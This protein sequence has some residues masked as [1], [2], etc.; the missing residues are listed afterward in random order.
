MNDITLFLTSLFSYVYSY[1]TSEINPRP[2]VSQITNN[3]DMKVVN[4]YFVIIL[5]I[6]IRSTNNICINNLI[7]ILLKLISKKVAVILYNTPTNVL[8]LPII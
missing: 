3:S 6:K 8:Y 4:Q 7:V 2:R 5:E 1:H